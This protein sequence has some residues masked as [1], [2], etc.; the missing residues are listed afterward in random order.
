M[1]LTNFCVNLVAIVYDRFGYATVLLTVFI[2]KMK[3]T[4][5]SSTGRLLSPFLPLLCVCV[6]CCAILRTQATCISTSCINNTNNDVVYMPDC[7][8]T[9]QNDAIKS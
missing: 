4:V 1:G 2:E 8:L 3:K 5:V 9:L 7:N 6:V